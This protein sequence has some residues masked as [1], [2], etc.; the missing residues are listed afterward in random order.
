[1]TSFV[2]RP[3]NQRGD[4]GRRVEL[5][6]A[7]ARCEARLDQPQARVALGT[8][9]FKVN[10]SPAPTWCLAL[11]SHHSTIHARQSIFAL[12]SRR[13]SVALSSYPHYNHNQP[14]QCLPRRLPLLRQ[15]RRPLS[16]PLMPHTKVSM[17][18]FSTTTRSFRVRSSIVW[19]A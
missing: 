6:D 3:A 19:V 8:Y 12:P 14:S 16:P 2:A 13:T 17:S 9:K 10:S 1:M 11:H 15:P 5:A 7:W 18:H 4:Q